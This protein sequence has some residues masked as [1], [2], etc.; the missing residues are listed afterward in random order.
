MIIIWY[1]LFSRSFARHLENKLSTCCSF[2]L[3]SIIVVELFCLKGVLTQNFSTMD[4]VNSKFE[5]IQKLHS[6]IIVVTLKMAS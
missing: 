4:L 1:L 3:V 2:R 6:Q 5:K